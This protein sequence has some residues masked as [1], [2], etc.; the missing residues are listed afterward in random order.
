M[1]NLS[2]KT[3]IVAMGLLVSVCLFAGD[4]KWMDNF[5][6]A[7]AA[8]KKEKKII[9][10]DFTGSDWC[11]CC[12]KLEKEVFNTLEFKKYADEKLILFKADFPKEN[13][14]SIE[15]KDQNIRLMDD[16]DVTGFPTIILLTSKGKVVFTTGYQEGGPKPYIESLKKA[17]AAYK[18]EKA[19]N[20]KS[21]TTTEV[22]PVADT[23]KKETKSIVNS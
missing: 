17:I 19:T 23:A 16:Y 2:F 1:R 4:I 14:Q 3:A 22:S 20:K 7:Q 12:I 8:A 10:A 11:P 6:D 21:K 13:T 5:A 18:A 9:L 15:M